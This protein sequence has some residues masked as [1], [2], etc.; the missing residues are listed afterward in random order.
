[1]S[2]LQSAIAC[3]RGAAESIRTLAEEVTESLPADGWSSEPGGLVQAFHDSPADET[4]WLEVSDSSMSAEPAAVAAHLAG[5][6]PTVALTVAAALD[7]QADYLTELIRQHGPQGER[8]L[9]EDDKLLAVARTYL[10]AD[11]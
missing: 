5:W 3:L 6:S 2:P 11:Q 8:Y 9:P 10:S 7:A 4:S 1:M